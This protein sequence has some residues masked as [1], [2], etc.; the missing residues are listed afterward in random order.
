MA[1]R[2]LSTTVLRAFSAVD[3]V[4]AR[5][6]R[7]V[8]PDGAGFQPVRMLELELT[9]PGPGQLGPA[10]GPDSRYQRARVLVRR[11]GRPVGAVDTELENGG[12]AGSTVEEIQAE[13]AIDEAPGSTRTPD[14]M[15]GGLRVTVVV[16]TH[17]RPADLRRCLDSVLATGYPEL[18]VV[19]VDNAPSSQDARRLVETS[20]PGVTYVRE[21]LPGTGCAHNRAL[22]E[23]GTPIVAITD[24]DVV[25]DR[26]WV[27]SLAAAFATG[28][29][30]VGCVT[31]LIWPAEL[32][33]AAQAAIESH[34]AFGKGFETVRFAMDGGQR[35]ADPLFPYTSGRFGSGANMAFRTEVLRGLGGFDPLLGTGAPGRGG[36][37]LAVFADV[38]LAGHS[39]V[40]EPAALVHHRHR[41]DAE[42]VRAQ[43][44]NYGVGLSA[45]LTSLAL[46]HPAV[47]S[48]FVRLAPQAIRHVLRGSSTRQ[49]EGQ[50]R[51]R[52]LLVLQLLGMAAGPWQY[53]SGR[54]SGRHRPKGVAP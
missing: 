23:V 3:H 40:Y 31:G 33:T 17:D 9:A 24:D 49:A 14:A 37:E 4:A 36:Q 45:Y 38:I 35:P 27:R 42:A 11:Q 54:R 52:E 29:P 41:R 47:L 48:D 1:A 2:R 21:D 22:A 34:G 13:F 18:E 28:G 19:V 12:L 39:L 46:H 8:E 7:N 6:D 16:A 43:A 5:R 10:G 26:D 53:L 15:P 20:Y 25:V 51:G 32:E 30:A 44:F 50:G